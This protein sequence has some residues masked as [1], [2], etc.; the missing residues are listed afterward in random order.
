MA[1]TKALSR[2]QSVMRCRP[3]SATASALPQAPAPRT[4]IFTTESPD[5]G[6]EPVREAVASL[7]VASSETPDLIDLHVPDLAVDVAHLEPSARLRFHDIEGYSLL[8]P[9]HQCGLLA[10]GR[11]HVG[12]RRRDDDGAFVRE[13]LLLHPG[14]ITR[15]IAHLCPG[16]DIDD[17]FD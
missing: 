11:P 7:R 5:G 4:A 6:D 17:D 15:L 3:A 8:R 14:E 9:K 12:D 16:V 13:R 1:E 10:W 2:A